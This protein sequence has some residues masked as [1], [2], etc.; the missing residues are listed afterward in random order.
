M[1]WITSFYHAI[2][3]AKV[4]VEELHQVLIKELNYA[5]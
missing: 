5:G 2:G 3:G 1:A 4:L